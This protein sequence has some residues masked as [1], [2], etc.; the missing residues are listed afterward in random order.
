[1]FAFELFDALAQRRSRQA[2]GAALEG[3]IHLDA[4]T[5][6]H[7]RVVAVGELNAQEV[8]KIP[9]VAGV[10]CD[11]R[12]AQG[13]CDRRVALR[14]FDP[15]LLGH[16][17]QHQI[18]A[19]ARTLGIAVG[20]DAIRTL[21]QRSKQSGL[22]ETQ[23]VDPLAKKAKRRFPDSMYLRRTALPEVDLV[24]IGFENFALV[25]AELDEQS[26]HRLVSLS[27]QGSL[28]REEEVL[29]ELLGERAAALSNAACTQIGE[30]RPTDAP[31]VDSR[32]RLEALILDGDNRV[33]EVGRKIVEPDEFAL[34]PIGS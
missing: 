20:R 19:L 34:L 30:K 14:G 18:A 16:Q 29:D 11:R 4:L 25:V 10:G 6:Q 5:R 32:M 2:L 13:L 1:M 12:E 3:R 31:H 8:E 28:G 24:Q 7:G 23:V 9:R 17:R 15:A 27:L 26:H 22:G 33:D 21:D